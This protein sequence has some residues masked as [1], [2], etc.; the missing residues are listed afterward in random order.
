MDSKTVNSVCSQIYRRFPEVNGVHPKV[1]P[2]STSVQA[3]S[4]YLLIFK[5]TAT[6]ADGKTLPRI[7]RATIDEQ[8]KI[9][10]VTTSR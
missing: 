6:T 2:Q 4:T 3:G 8:G 5:S 1:Q 9:L 7:V 10:K